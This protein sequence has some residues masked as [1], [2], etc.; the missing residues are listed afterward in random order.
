[1][2]VSQV[3]TLT[4]AVT[5]YIQ[6]NILIALKVGSSKLRLGED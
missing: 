1:M 4:L 6:M 2:R 5:I 3:K